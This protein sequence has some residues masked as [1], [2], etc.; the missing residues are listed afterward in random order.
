MNYAIKENKISELGRCFSIFR[1]SKVRLMQTLHRIGGWGGQELEF[2]CINFFNIKFTFFKKSE[3]HHLKAKIMQ[4]KHVFLIFQT[5]R[6]IGV[7]EDTQKERF[8]PFEL[9]CYKSF[10]IGTEYYF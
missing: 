9:L 8:Q 1:N 4:F 7:L 2:S 5:L 6:P 10:R 3:L